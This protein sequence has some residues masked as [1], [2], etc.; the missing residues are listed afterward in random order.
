VTH[1]SQPK[2]KSPEATGW[3]LHFLPCFVMAGA[4]GERKE[5]LPDSHPSRLYLHLFQTSADH[6]CEF[7]ATTPDGLHDLRAWSFSGPSGFGFLHRNR[8]MRCWAV[9]VN[10][11]KII[12]G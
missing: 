4:Q 6:S 10:K 2:A 7:M 3:A 1:P 5:L 9:I 12:T 8:S 11:I